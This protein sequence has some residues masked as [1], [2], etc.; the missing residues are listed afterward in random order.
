MKKIKLKI[1]IVKEGSDAC[2]DGCSFE[3]FPGGCKD[4][5]KLLTG[6][7]CLNDEIIFKLERN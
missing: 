2:C 3:E 4:A 6:V 1:K 7:D 5:M